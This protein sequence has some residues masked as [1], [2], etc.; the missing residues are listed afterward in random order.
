MSIERLSLE[1]QLMLGASAT[2][3][4]HIG[5][6]ALLDGTALLD[7][8]GRLRIDAVRDA[9]A[10]R[11]HLLRRFRQRIHVPRRGLGPP[12]WV[13][14]PGF[15]LGEHVRVLPLRAPLGEVELLDA[16]EQLWRRPMDPSR[17]LWEIWLMT[18][19][20]ERRVG[21]FVKMHHAMG[22]GIA[23]MTT[24]A[25]FLD[26]G[27]DA[28]TEPPRP[29]TPEPIPS[30]GR[31][32]ADTLGRHVA[33]FVAA[34]SIL[35][36]PWTALR[37]M[38]AA[39]PATRELIAEEPAPRTSLDRLVGV[40]RRLAVVR[41]TVDRVREI[42]HCHDATVNDV[43]LAATAGGLRTLLHG[44]GDRVEGTTVRIYVPVSLRRRLR[45]PQH[46]NLIAQMVVPVRFDASDPGLR[47]RHIAAETTTRKARSRMP[48]GTLFR[49]RLA[50]RLILKAV[51]RQR[52]N[53]TTASIPGPTKPMYLAGAR[54][55]EVVPVLPLIGKVALGVGVVSYAG[56]FAIGITADR[57]AYPDLERFTAGVRDEL[58]AL[59]IATDAVQGRSSATATS[60]VRPP[61]ARQRSATAGPTPAVGRSGGG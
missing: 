11:L 16:I 50:T 56:T 46:G 20:P 32:L 10:G 51:N 14:A 23:A 12:L 4:Q 60:G 43:L 59:G 52:V 36:R 35:V 9:I 61:P 48:L 30:T 5:A 21:L 28:P 7:A 42:A 49:G 25:A 15:A 40:D 38:A 24:V 17:P 44:R 29:W 45:G 47:L 22:D 54:M 53:V 31:L 1:D 18:G 58:H 6:F 55:L 37:Q 19:L 8:S 26:T 2:W 41:T 27:P 34:L 3:P 57:D 39:W 13:D 33:G